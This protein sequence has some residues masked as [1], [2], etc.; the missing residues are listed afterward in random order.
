MQNLI[1]SATYKEVVKATEKKVLLK[2]MTK[3]FGDISEN[4]QQKLQAIDSIEQLDR[5]IDLVLTASS[6][7]EFVDFTNL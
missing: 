4:I 3:R 2:I 5:L 6:L 7:E 1:Q